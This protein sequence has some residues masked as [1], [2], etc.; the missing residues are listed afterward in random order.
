MRIYF[1]LFLL[2]AACQPN[3]PDDFHSEGAS[4]TKA[5]ILDLREVNSKEK[6]L[7]LAPKVKKKIQKL[8][9]LMI[10]AAK[11]QSKHLGE[12]DLR[13]SSDHYYSDLL[14]EEFKRIYAIQGCQ[15]IMEGLQRDSLHQLDA[16][17]KSMQEVTR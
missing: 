7:E 11:Y 10:G 3:S 2:F 16:Y 12:I 14:L 9:D 1:F 6:F 13:E 4:I 5:L 15:E 17:L 8:T